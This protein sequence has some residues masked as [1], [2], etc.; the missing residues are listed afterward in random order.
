MKYSILLLLLHHFLF[1]FAQTG[2]EA[3]VLAAEQ[4]RFDAMVKKDTAA[5]ERMLSDDL[6]FIHSNSLQE[7][8]KEHLVSIGTGSINYQNMQ[9]VSV[10]VRLFGK[11]AVTNGN[12]LAKGLVNQ[13]AFD[14]NLTYTA[15]YKK[16]KKSWQL[17][18]WQSTRIP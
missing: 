1:G 7:S 2:N 14:V 5:L 16:K 6:I 11:I 15:I 13:K 10:Q 4:M 8:K 3:S 17:V 9:R 18:N 12:L